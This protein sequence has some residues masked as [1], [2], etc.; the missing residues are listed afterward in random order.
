MLHMKGSQ[1]T[2]FN[3]HFFRAERLSTSISLSELKSL[4]LP[5]IFHGIKKIHI[6]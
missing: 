2:I 6:H 4:K 1:I 3:N 5:E